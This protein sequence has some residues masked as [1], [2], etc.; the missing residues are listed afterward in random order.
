[1]ANFLFYRY[2]FE[3]SGEKD[4]FSVKEQEYVSNDSLN[5]KLKEN[6]HSI[7]SNSGSKELNLYDTKIDRNGDQSSE[8]FINE[9]IKI[10]NGIVL[11]QVRNNKH[12]KIMPKDRT[13]ALE[14][15]H[16]P[17]CWVIIDPRPDSQAILVQYKKEVFKNSDKVTGMLVD[18]FSRALRLPELGWELRPKKRVCEGTI[19]NIV[20]LRTAKGQDRV[21]SLSIKFDEKRPDTED[22]VTTALQMILTKLNSPEG[23]L[24]LSSEDKARIL[25]D[26]TQEDVRRTVDLL[27]ENKYRMKIVF[28]KSG[29]VEYGKEAD[30]IYGVSDSVC[31][32]FAEGTTKF[33]D[34]GRS[35]TGLE[36]WLDTLMSDNSTQYIQPKKKNGRKNSK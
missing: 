28:E 18:Y 22:D 10:I 3:Q 21:K 4:L 29:I 24:I 36:E 32:D 30:A 17:F 2:N 13:E 26:K 8:I 35:T 31:D 1:M 27:I 5:G 23:E 19:W 12:K 15:E 20:S 11:L 34:N 33:D 9:I 7:Y 6:L 25:L 16:Y 14:V